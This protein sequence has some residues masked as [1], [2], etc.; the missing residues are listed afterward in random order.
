MTLVLTP[1]ETLLAKAQEDAQNIIR[2]REYRDSWEYKEDAVRR[3]VV[4]CAIRYVDSYFDT[5]LMRTTYKNLQDAVELAKR[6]VK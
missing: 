1:K 3:I 6:Y 5:E 2:A 4:D